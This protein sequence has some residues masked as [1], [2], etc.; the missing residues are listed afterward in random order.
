VGQNSPG[1]AQAFGS[2]APKA[3]LSSKLT[4]HGDLDM[5][6]TSGNDPRMHQSSPLPALTQD[7]MR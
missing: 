7:E 6:P 1:E 4:R 3:D 2:M 5:P